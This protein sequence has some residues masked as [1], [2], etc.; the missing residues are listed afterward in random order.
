MC[1]CVS[2]LMIFV[3]FFLEIRNEK[4]TMIQHS[5]FLPLC[6]RDPIPWP[7]WWSCSHQ[8]SPV[9]SRSIEVRQQIAECLGICLLPDGGPEELI[10]V[11]LGGN[12]S[13]PSRLIMDV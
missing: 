12:E 13:R 9:T 8:R 11:R 2:H 3:W 7:F 4:K 5:H 10:I 1:V 6:S